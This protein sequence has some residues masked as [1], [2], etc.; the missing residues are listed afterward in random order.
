MSSS[1]AMDLSYVLM[2]PYH[3]LLRKKDWTSQDQTNAILLNELEDLTWT[4]YYRGISRLVHLVS[5]ELDYRIR[6]KNYSELSILRELDYRQIYQDFDHGNPEEN[7]DRR[8]GL[9][10][11][12][13][14]D[15]L[16]NRIIQ[17]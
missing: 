11:L 14:K 6:G 17:S 5:V 7:R 8:R 13:D 3:R 10:Y 15:A 2:E 12:C 16:V 9:L 1:S 4:Q